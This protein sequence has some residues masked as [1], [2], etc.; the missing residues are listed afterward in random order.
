MY[1]KEHRFRKGDAEGL[2]IRETNV[3]LP[4]KQ[5]R[6]VGKEED[7]KSWQRHDIKVQADRA[8]LFGRRHPFNGD[9]G[10]RLIQLGT[11]NQRRWG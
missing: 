11:A 3:N 4:T 10:R 6:I 2:Q 9:V 5:T 8:G 7:G 1:K